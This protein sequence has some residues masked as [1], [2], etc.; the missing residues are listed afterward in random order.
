MA[1]EPIV[2][3]E[4]LSCES[5]VIKQVG[6]Y[7]YGTIPLSTTVLVTLGLSIE[8]F[9]NVRTSQSFKSNQVDPKLGVIWA[10]S[11]FTTIRAAG[12][13]TL[14]RSQLVNQTLEPTHVAGFNQFFDDINGTDAKQYG[15]GVDHKISASWLAGLELL[16]RDLDVPVSSELIERQKQ[17][18]H[19]AYLNFA[20]SN[21]LALSAEIYFTIPHEISSST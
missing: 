21:Q 10:L 3:R 11:R 8:R 2:P 5:S 9:E 14:K 6:G 17:K 20:P 16:R 1:G 18:F 19:R 13:R 15:I 12:L 7:A 4:C